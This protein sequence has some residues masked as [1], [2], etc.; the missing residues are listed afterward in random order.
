M[1]ENLDLTI[2]YFGN[3]S[4][5]KIQAVVEMVKE[6]YERIG[7]K[8]LILEIGPGI[9]FWVNKIASILQAEGI[10][11]QFI[12]I[13]LFFFNS[14]NSFHMSQFFETSHNITSI[15]AD[16]HFFNWEEF[17]DTIKAFQECPILL[18]TSTVFDP[19]VRVNTIS[20][21]LRSCSK[22]NLYG[23]QHYEG[24]A[25]TLLNPLQKERLADSLGSLN[26]NDWPRPPQG[27]ESSLLELVPKRHAF[28]YLNPN[29]YSNVNTALREFSEN[30]H[31]KIERSIPFQELTASPLHLTSWKMQ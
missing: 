24:D 13:E 7:E 15:Y 14:I 6:C 11:Y 8:V 3:L 5:C 1:A 10:P 12:C 16:A 20:E 23:G 2:N 28:S 9:G 31:I 17:L 27:L 22:Y 29:Y 26:F 4:Y 18:H 21:I 25:F 30:N 19:F